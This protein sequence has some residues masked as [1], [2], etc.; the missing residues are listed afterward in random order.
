MCFLR[1][2]PFDVEIASK[3]NNDDTLTLLG[4][5]IISG[6]DEL[7]SYVIFRGVM[8]LF[9]FQYLV[10]RKNFRANYRILTPLLDK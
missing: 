8:I 4:D 1:K 5:S 9:F 3:A 10:R 6:V 7:V 2:S